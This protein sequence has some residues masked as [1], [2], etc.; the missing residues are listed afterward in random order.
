VEDLRKAKDRDK[1]NKTIAGLSSFLDAVA[2]DDKGGQTDFSLLLAQGYLTITKYTKA[3]A[4]LEKLPAPNPK[5]DARDREEGL[6]RLARVLWIRAL[7]LEGKENGDEKS[8]KKAEELMTEAMG[9]SQAP[10]WGRRDVNALIEE[11]YLFTDLGYHGAAVNRANALLKTLLPLL[12]RGGAMKERYFE[13]YYLFINAYN[14]HALAQKEPA[15]RDEEI[16]TVAGH[17]QKLIANHADL[18]GEESR[19]RFDDLL[20]SDEGALLKKAL[21]ELQ[22]KAKQN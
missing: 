7:R 8:L 18:G 20:A 10:G 6:R 2:K 5:G 17:L 22:A 12:N 16:K 14:R 1:L 15:K 3:I 21:S 11:I 4:L 9:T 19:Q 13:A